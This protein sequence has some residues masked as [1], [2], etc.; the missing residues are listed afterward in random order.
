MNQSKGRRTALIVLLLCLALFI[1]L[2]LAIAKP[3]NPSYDPKA[4]KEPEQG[5]LQTIVLK[6]SDKLSKL[7][8]PRQ[9]EVTKQAINTYVKNNISFSATS[10]SISGEPQATPKGVIAFDF[11]VDNGVGTI[12]ATI[13]KW[14]YYDKIIFSVPSKSYSVTLPVYTN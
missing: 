7:L 6:N 4:P 13:D 12:T 1:G 10:V 11:R 14:T 9:F 5:G 8:L 2:W 3:F